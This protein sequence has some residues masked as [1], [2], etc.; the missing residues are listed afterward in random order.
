VVPLTL[1]FQSLKVSYGIINAGWI[2]AL[3]C[4]FLALLALLGLE[5]THGKD[6][7]YVEEQLNP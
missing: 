3:F 2:L 6:L 5:E 4:S 7:N 1:S